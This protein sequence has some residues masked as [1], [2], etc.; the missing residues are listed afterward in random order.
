[1]ALVACCELAGCSAFEA[2]VP[3]HCQGRETYREEGLG[4]WVRGNHYYQSLLGA[5]VVCDAVADFGEHAHVISDVGHVIS[6]LGHVISAIDHVI[7]VA[8][9][10]MPGGSPAPQFHGCSTWVLADHVI[11]ADHV[12]VKTGSYCVTKDVHPPE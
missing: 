8:D 10:V 3:A 4:N 9:F 11:S 7:F 6:A 12:P 2:F 5:V 1:M